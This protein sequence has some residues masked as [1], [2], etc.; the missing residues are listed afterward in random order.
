MAVKSDYRGGLE[1]TGKDA[2]WFENYMKKKPSNQKAR[3]AIRRALKDTKEYEQKGWKFPLK[4][5]S[6]AHK[7]TAE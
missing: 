6:G 4:T 5:D 2:E 3:D 1:L 7:R